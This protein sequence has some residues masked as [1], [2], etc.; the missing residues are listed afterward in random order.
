MLT[1]LDPND[2]TAH[3]PALSSALTEPN[4]LLA[5]GGSLS[6]EWLLKAY[7]LGIFPWFEDDQPI[8]WW[9]PDPRLTL[10][11]CQVHIS[12]SLRK[13]I[14]KNNYHCTVDNAFSHVIRACSQPRLTHD[15]TWITDSM[16]VAYETLFKLGHAHS[17]EVWQED[18]LVGGLYGVSIGQVFFGESMFSRHTNASKVAFVFLCQQLE[19]WGGQLIDCQ[20]HSDHLASLGASSISRADFS[21]QLNQLCSQ[22]LTANAWDNS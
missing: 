6:P 9:S 8:L 19:S 7:R 18:E 5:A 14:N 13:F 3:F 22:P 4:G 2:A 16:V 21:K 11:P 15:E 12:R 1:W 10:K 20:V 17:I